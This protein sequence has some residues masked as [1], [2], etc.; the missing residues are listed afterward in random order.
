MKL[1]LFSAQRVASVYCGIVWICILVEIPLNCWALFIYQ[2]ES[3]ELAQISA[4]QTSNCQT[5][6]E[7]LRALTR[8]LAVEVPHR[9]NHEYFLLPVFSILRP[10]SLQVIKEGGDCS[11][12]SRVLVSLLRHRKIPAKKLSLHTPAGIGSHAAVLAHTERGDYVIDALYG[13]VFDHEDGS[14]I[15]LDD[16][17]QRPEILPA[18]IERE[19][20][21]GNTKARN[22]SCERYVYTDVRSWDLEQYPSTAALRGVL[23][24]VFGKSAIDGLPRP[25]FM[26]EPALIMMWASAG[27]IAILST[28]VALGRF[29]ARRRMG[30]PPSQ[31]VVGSSSLAGTSPPAF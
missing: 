13:I 30:R 17:Q 26:A 2:T 31:D 24:S 15:S 14:P 18:I 25:P 9:K 7:A 1:N 21:R 16:L 3:A 20:A 27:L 29:I 5:D 11:Y 10:T 6:S 28:P 12:K 23:V 19:I 4:R 22:Y 8:Y